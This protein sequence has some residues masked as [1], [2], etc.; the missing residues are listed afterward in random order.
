MCNYKIIITI[1]ECSQDHIGFLGY[2]NARELTVQAG[3]LRKSR[4]KTRRAPAETTKSV[5]D[6]T[7]NEL[8]KELAVY[9]CMILWKYFAESQYRAYK[10]ILNTILLCLEKY[11]LIWCRRR[12]ID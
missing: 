5:Y 8:N 4:Q 7:V 6:Y 1:I 3:W 12:S 9:V 11:T 2:E 10:M